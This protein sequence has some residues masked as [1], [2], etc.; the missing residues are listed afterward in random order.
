M[1]TINP[2]FRNFEKNDKMELGEDG[3]PVDELFDDADIDAALAE[4]PPRF[5][6]SDPD[7]KHQNAAQALLAAEQGRLRINTEVEDPGAQQIANEALNPNLALPAAYLLANQIYNLQTAVNIDPTQSTQ[8][9][10]RLQKKLE[11]LIERSQICESKG[12]QPYDNEE[13]LSHALSVEQNALIAAQG[14]DNPLGLSASDKYGQG[15]DMAFLCEALGSLCEKELSIRQ[16][17]KL[18]NPNAAGGAGKLHVGV[19]TPKKITKG[20]E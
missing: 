20:I 18:P 4:V 17:T 8:Q 19:V 2:A 3:D 1:L 7:E 9:I 15:E 12:A 11:G 14:A 6:Y 10:A 13:G 5:L 16:S